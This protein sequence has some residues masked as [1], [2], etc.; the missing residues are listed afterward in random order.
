MIKTIAI[1]AVTTALSTTAAFA[2]GGGYQWNQ[3]GPTSTD[4]AMTQPAEKI[5]ATHPNAYVKTPTAA[6]VHV[7][8]QPAKIFAQSLNSYAG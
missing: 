1:V 8:V 4:A 6:D 7:T 3:S 2:Q 5:T